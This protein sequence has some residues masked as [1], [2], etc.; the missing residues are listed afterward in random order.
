VGTTQSR[1]G[2]SDTSATRAQAEPRERERGQSLVE[3]SLVVPLLFFMLLAILDFSRIFTA[4]LTIESA[5]R[6]AADFGTQYPGYW[7]G[8]PNDPTSNAG[9]T[10]QGMI[11]RACTA[12]K[13]QTDYVGPD[14]ACTNPTFNYAID[15]PTGVNP[16]DCH[17]I[18]RTAEPCNITVTLDY[19]FHLIAPVNILWFDG[20]LGFPST[21]AF[22]RTS[23]FA[24]SDFQIDESLPTPAP[25]P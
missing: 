1:H 15:P 7:E 22:Q 12:S 20:T 10:V 4:Q 23:T 25:G 5:A 18:A 3:F 2:L 11:E 6:E 16:E 24:I 8:D 9:K 21:L 19:T 14:T 13:H 17:A